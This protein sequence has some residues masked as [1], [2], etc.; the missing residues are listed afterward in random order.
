MADLKLF[1]RGIPLSL[2]IV[3]Y[4]VYVI[5]AVGIVW[6]VSFMAISA[7]INI[8]AVYPASYGAG[9]VDETVE[10]LCST[11]E[12]DPDAVPTAYRYVRIDDEGTVLGGDLPDEDR[13]SALR[14]ARDYLDGEDGQTERGQAAV[15]GQNGVTYTVFELPDGSICLLASDFMPQFV[16]RSLRDALPNP[17]N[18]MLVAACAGSVAS[19]LLIS[20]RASR[21]IARKMAPL[22][23]AADRIAHED[24]AFTVGT[25]NV[26]QINDVLGAMERMRSSLKESL[27]AHWRAEQ[28]QRNQVAALAHDLKTPLTVVRA[29]ADYVAE[30]TNDMAAAK[31]PPDAG[32]LEDIAAAARDTAA[33]A[34]RLDDYVRLLIEAS[35]GEAAAEDEGKAPVRLDALAVELGQ[36]AGAL[37]RAAGVALTVDRDSSIEGMQLEADR[38]ALGRAVMN[39]VAN[40]LDHAQKQVD[41][42]FGCE[43]GSGV[44]AVKVDDDGPGFSP[45]ALEHGCERFFCGD[46]SR[47]GAMMGGHY[48]IGL[49]TAS[50]AAHA[51]GGTVEISNR[52][53]EAGRIL[54]A[55]VV[56]RIP[57]LEK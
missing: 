25:S 10:A 17:Q 18:I 11:P 5:V 15:T 56:V 8:G 54:G 47:G 26:R 41:L 27:E 6:V 42:S 22:T 57:V 24:L 46:S 53:G 48:G 31:S 9:H 30:E 14:I 13:E 4:F 23:D 3:R 29:N 49:S 43:D 55:R 52:V 44:F 2:V 36:E 21:I 34:G 20:H 16:S 50:D 40:A 28:A 1:G 38:E 37:A 12:F 39:V 33:A 45:E 51:H 19:I 35:R 7:S 32:E